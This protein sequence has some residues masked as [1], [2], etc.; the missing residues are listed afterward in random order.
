MPWMHIKLTFVLLLYGYHFYNHRLFT[1]LQND[2]YKMSSNA[3][4]MW[5]ELATLILFAVVFLV[6]FKDTTQW[7]KGVVGLIAFAGLLMFAIKR[8][9]KIREKNKQ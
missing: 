4:R 9:K 8:Y 7:I 3:L 6:V 1:Q 5:N 2:T